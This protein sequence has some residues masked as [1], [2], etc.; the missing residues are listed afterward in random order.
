M[1]FRAI[2]QMPLAD[3]RSAIALFLQRSREQCFTRWDAAGI[4]HEGVR[5]AKAHGVPASKQPGARRRALNAGSVEL[6]E[7]NALFGEAIDVRRFYF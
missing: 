7:A 6:R 3:Q 1:I 2:T 4:F 5:Q